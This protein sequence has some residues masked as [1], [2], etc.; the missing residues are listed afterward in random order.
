MSAYTGKADCPSKQLAD[1]EDRIVVLEGNSVGGALASGK[2]LVG[3]GS[4]VAAAVTP[5]GDV[6][7]DNTGTTAIGAGKVLLAMLGTG[8]APS[9]VCIAA[10]VFTTVGGSANQT[11]TIAG[12]LA[13]DI[14]VASLAQKGAVPV[15]ILT[16]I[17]AAGQINVVM[18]GDPSTDHKIAYHV[19]RAAA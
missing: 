16:A 18:S 7:I 15:T 12:L 2:I 3:N 9:H 17:A 8:I 6:T 1:H 4:G 10:G 14:V 5:S 11:I 19:M 13:T